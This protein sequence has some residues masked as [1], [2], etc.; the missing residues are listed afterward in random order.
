[1][2]SNFSRPENEIIHKPSN[3][4]LYLLNS[5]ENPDWLYEMILKNICHKT[6]DEVKGLLSDI[7]GDG[8]GLIGIFSYDVT[9]TKGQTIRSISKEMGFAVD[10]GLRKIK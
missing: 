5:D 2:S 1:M 7:R 4:E 10:C 8:A 6:K 9:T 3:Y